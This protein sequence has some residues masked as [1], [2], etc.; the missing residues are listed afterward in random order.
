MAGGDPA[1]GKKVGE[2]NSARK[3]YLRTG[4]PAHRVMSSAARQLAFS[5]HATIPTICF[6]SIVRTPRAVVPRR[7]TRL[8]RNTHRYRR[9]R[10]WSGWIGCCE[11]R[12]RWSDGR[13]TRSAPAILERFANMVG[14][15]S[16]CAPPGLIQD[17][18][19]CCNCAPSQI[20]VGGDRPR[21]P[22]CSTH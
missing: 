16:S 10:G 19:S 22:V 7:P 20:A 15:P 8:T 13:T 11:A 4:G 14:G 2:I 1:A 18:P 6:V 3:E 17:G 9:Q 5:V 12:P 21:R